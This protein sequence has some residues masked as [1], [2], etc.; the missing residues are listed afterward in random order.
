MGTIKH[1]GFFSS[2]FRLS[3]RHRAEL[4]ARGLSASTIATIE[5]HLDFLKSFYS[6]DPPSRRAQCPL[7]A[8]VNEKLSAA[9]SAL[10]GLDD[11]TSDKMEAKAFNS[12]HY[13]PLDALR[14]TLAN[15]ADAARTLATRLKPPPGPDASQSTHV[16]SLVGQALRADGIPLDDSLKG[17][18]V[19]ATGIALEAFGLNTREPRNS[20][21][22]ALQVIDRKTR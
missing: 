10:M 4:T 2:G 21:R 18:Y 9:A 13:L 11:L 15:Y 17:P 22:R 7:L 14:A 19:I 12:A 3:D 6:T 16:A 1:T 8:D 5:D 20:V